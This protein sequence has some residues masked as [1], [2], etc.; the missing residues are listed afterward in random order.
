[1]CHL[2]FN[3]SKYHSKKDIACKN[4][5]I[6]VKY[7]VEIFHDDRLHACKCMYID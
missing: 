6:S 7:T 1:M 2:K 5:K 3:N 4:S